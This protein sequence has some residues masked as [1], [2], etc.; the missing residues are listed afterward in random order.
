MPAD[1]TLPV[2]VSLDEETNVVA[3]ADPLRSTL[4]PETN[5]EPVAVRLMLPGLVEVGEMLASEGMGLRRVTADESD[6]EV[7]ATLVA[8]TDTVLGEGREVGAV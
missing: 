7:S 5:E 4:A 8:V 1:E 2:A 6:F 3:R